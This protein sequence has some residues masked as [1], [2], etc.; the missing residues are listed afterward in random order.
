MTVRTININYGRNK[1]LMEKCKPLADYAAFIAYIRENLK[2]MSL[3]N[4]VRTA[5]DACI[6]QNILRDF[7]VEQKAEVI[8][9]SIYEY[10]EENAKKYYFSEGYEDGYDEGKSA[11]QTL[12]K[13]TS[14]LEN[15]ASIM[16]NLNIS[17][18][19]ACELLGVTVEDYYLAEQNLA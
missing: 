4:A 16:K 9:M 10:D 18:S 2:T 8:A 5:V 12:G 3:E 17:L 19:K 1:A 14:L 11:G 13:A 7:L 6:D 15:V